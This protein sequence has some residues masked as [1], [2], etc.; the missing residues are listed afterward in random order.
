MWQSLNVLHTKNYQQLCNRLMLSKKLVS[1]RAKLLK[2]PMI[3]HARS[4][5]QLE[6]NGSWRYHKERYSKDAPERSR[7]CNGFKKPFSK[8]LNVGVIFNHGSKNDLNTRGRVNLLL[9]KLR[10]AGLT[11]VCITEESY[12]Q[13]DK[14]T[15]ALAFGEDIERKTQSLGN[16]G[17]VILYS[18]R[19]LSPSRYAAFKRSMDLTKRRASVCLVVDENFSSKICGVAAKINAKL[20]NSYNHMVD[21]HAD[22]R[23]SLEDTMI[24]GASLRHPDNGACNGAPS[25]I[26]LVSCHAGRAR[27]QDDFGLVWG[28]FSLQTSHSAALRKETSIE[29][30]SYTP[31]LVTS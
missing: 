6:D 24:L 13:M 15:S 1:I 2:L 4:S 7:S 28:S 3:E 11:D 16:P 19:P 9:A 29:V 25:V 31:E 30:S 17:L 20:C 23:C 8:R 18:E 26:S 21:L 22:E 5:S 14:H 27:T 10:D 12:R